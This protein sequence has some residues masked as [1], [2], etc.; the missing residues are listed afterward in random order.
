LSTGQVRL[1]ALFGVKIHGK[2]RIIKAGAV[3][4]H[5][6]GLFLCC[7]SDFY[8]VALYRAGLQQTGKVTGLDCESIRNG[9]NN[10]IHLYGKNVFA[11]G[12]EIIDLLC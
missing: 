6:S 5:C 11:E 4:I 1:I 2:H 3:I 8:M 10:T 12:I 7:N 9:Q